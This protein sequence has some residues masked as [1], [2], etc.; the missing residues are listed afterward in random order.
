MLKS[1]LDGIKGLGVKRKKLLEKFYPDLRELSVATP[2]E[3]K[4][5]GIPEKVAVEVIERVR[6]T[7]G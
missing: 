1:P 3:L 6:K 4:K 5:I 2:E 7:F